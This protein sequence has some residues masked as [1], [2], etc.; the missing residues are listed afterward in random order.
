MIRIGG[1]VLTGAKRMGSFFSGGIIVADSGEG[2][3]RVRAFRHPKRE[4]GDAKPAD[5]ELSNHVFPRR[6]GFPMSTFESFL[7]PPM[8]PQGLSDQAAPDKAMEK[9]YSLAAD[10]GT[11]GPEHKDRAQ[12]V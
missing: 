7:P 10:W 8:R 11:L 4:N 5:S 1:L 6:R 2:A 3:A 9:H 12:N